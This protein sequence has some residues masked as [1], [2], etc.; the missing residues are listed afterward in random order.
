M[1]TTPQ[2]VQELE[3]PMGIEN[4]AAEHEETSVDSWKVR[5]ANWMDVE[6]I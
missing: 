4:L 6:L 2:Q 3:E 1:C 5:S